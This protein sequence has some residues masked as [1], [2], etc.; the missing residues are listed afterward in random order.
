M[1]RQVDGSR[2]ESSGKAEPGKQ[3]RLRDI[4]AW[5]RRKKGISSQKE[6][7]G[8]RP[9]Q[10]DGGRGYGRVGGDRDPRIGPAE[11]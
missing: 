8:V 9:H 11:S 3:D 5:T 1:A 10:G 4:Q 2:A 6:G 7:G